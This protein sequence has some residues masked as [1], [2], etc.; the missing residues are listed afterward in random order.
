MAGTQFP[1]LLSR[2][3]FSK[4]VEI[5][6]GARPTDM[7]AGVLSGVLTIRQNEL[8]LLHT[9]HTESSYIA[10]VSG[11]SKYHTPLMGLEL[12]LKLRHEG[13]KEA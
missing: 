10:S 13:T 1:E 2:L 12:C 7:D 9:L 5:G 8:P 4:E 6:F 11:S 3:R